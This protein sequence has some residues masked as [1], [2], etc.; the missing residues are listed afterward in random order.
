MVLLLECEISIAKTN[1]K[2]NACSSSVYEEDFIAS[3]RSNIVEKTDCTPL[4]YI[5]DKSLR[6]VHPIHFKSSVAHFVKCSHKQ[7][8]SKV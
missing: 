3:T 7:I 5:K 8:R 6:N 2:T 1:M 4:K